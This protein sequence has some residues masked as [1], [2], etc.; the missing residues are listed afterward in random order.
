M[1]ATALAV[2]R[3]SKHF[4]GVSALDQVSFTIEDGE[5]VGLIGPNGAGKTTLLRAI[6]GQVEPDDGR[7][8]LGGRSLAGMRTAQRARLGIGLSHQ[9]VRPFRNMSLLE[10]AMIAAGH[11]RTLSS[12]RALA[13][14]GRAES[15]A[16]ALEMLHRVGIDHLAEKYPTTQPLGVLKRLEVA[17]ALA[18]RPRVL[19][20][21]EPLAGLGPAAAGKLA[22]T[23][24]EI[25]Q[26][27]IAI[28]LIEH[29][30]GEAQKLCRRFVVLDNGK[31]IADG[32]MR[33]VFADGRVVDAYLGEG[34]RHAPAR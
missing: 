17:R 5:F 29:N 12:W 33:D 18:M 30:L 1:S 21:D 8:L 13:S 31:K 3:L 27:G 11:A 16:A 2:E 7:V 26:T 28:L 4:G 34:W 9:I 6:T 23:L 32:A 15:R 25:N 10:N 14:L 24:R 19:L 20:L 22:E